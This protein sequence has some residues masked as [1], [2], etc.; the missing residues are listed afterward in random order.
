[1]YEKEIDP[2]CD[3]RIHITLRGYDGRLD[4]LKGIPTCEIFLYPS[5]QWNAQNVK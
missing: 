4:V 1:M 3:G 2:K 5:L